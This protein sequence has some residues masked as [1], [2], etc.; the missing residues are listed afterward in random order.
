MRASLRLIS[1]YNM[2]KQKIYKYFQLSSALNYQNFNIAIAEFRLVDSNN[3]FWSIENESDKCFG[4][5]GFLSDFSRL[6]APTYGNMTP[7]KK[8]PK[9]ACLV[10]L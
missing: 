3:K 7:V 4:R 9:W 8:N 2:Q 10:S 1:V 6:N 5:C